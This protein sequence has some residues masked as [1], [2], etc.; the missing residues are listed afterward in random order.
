MT[1]GIGMFSIAQCRP[2]LVNLNKTI[3][4]MLLHFS[5][6]MDFWKQREKAQLGCNIELLKDCFSM[7]RALL[8]ME[9]LVSLEDFP[10]THYVKLKRI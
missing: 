6:W 7:S 8:I 10:S 9:T 1:L 2:K 5:I 3:T 4:V